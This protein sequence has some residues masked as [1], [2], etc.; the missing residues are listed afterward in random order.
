[1]LNTTTALVAD[2][3]KLQRTYSTSILTRL[4]FT[5]QTPRSGLF[6][7]GMSRPAEEAAMRLYAEVN[8]VNVRRVALFALCA[9]IGE[10]IV[11]SLLFGWFNRS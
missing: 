11:A 4:Q 10:L 7:G 8:R 9:F 3:A 1:M 5:C 6:M 2:G